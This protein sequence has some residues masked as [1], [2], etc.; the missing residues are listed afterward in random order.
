MSRTGSSRRL[1]AAALG[2]P[3]VPGEVGQV[4]LDA[5][6]G[7]QAGEPAPHELALCRRSVAALARLQRRG[8]LGIVV[9]ADP[10]AG[11]LPGLPQPDDERVALIA[12][13]QPPRPRFAVRAV[14]T[15][16]LEDLLGA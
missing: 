9:G 15:L 12:A 3:A 11:V 7:Q 10:A 16:L 6:A 2:V 8:V 13:A 14:R 4:E 5:L 1:P